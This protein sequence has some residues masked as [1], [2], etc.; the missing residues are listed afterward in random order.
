MDTR[1]VSGSTRTFGLSDLGASRNVETTD[2]RLSEALRIPVKIRLA[3]WARALHEHRDHSEFLLADSPRTLEKGFSC[4]CT[5][6]LV[7]W[8]IDIRALR[9]RIP[10]ARELLALLPIPRVP[11]LE[12]PCSK[13]QKRARALL[14]RF[15][16]KSQKADL[17]ASGAF[18]VKASDGFTYRIQKQ[19][20]I[21]RQ[22]DGASFC[23]HP[24][25]DLKVPFYDTM[26]AQKVLLESDL[27]TFLATAN[28][29]LRE[30]V[31]EN[32]PPRPGWLDI[33][34]EALENIAEWAD[35][36]L[37]GDVNGTE[38]NDHVRNAPVVDG[39]GNSPED[40]A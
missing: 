18:N 13:A 24:R 29:R 20:S 26:L 9:E 2:T 8:R 37:N 30:P 40:L 23:I 34:D 25:W 12:K 4:S 27:E 1:R 14:F 38:H 31:V 10:E 6:E 35:Y 32:P 3:N 33:G 15:L 16:T 39:Q 36:Q 17:R 5:G 21:L 28:K 11:Q 7:I 19:L 22:E